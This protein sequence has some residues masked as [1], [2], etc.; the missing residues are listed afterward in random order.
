MAIALGD[1]QTPQGCSAPKRPLEMPW[2]LRGALAG[3]SFGLVD[4][5][6]AYAPSGTPSDDLMSL[7]GVASSVAVWSLAGALGLPIASR[8]LGVGRRELGGRR[9][10]TTPE[11]LGLLVA[12]A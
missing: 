9:A 10:L 2:W 11:W 7:A 6:L 1:R 4:G 5:L 8:I 12:T 3:V